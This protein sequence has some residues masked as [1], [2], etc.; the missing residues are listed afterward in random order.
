VVGA[1][2]ALLAMAAPARAQMDDD[3]DVAPREF[4]S[5]ERFG[6]EFRI[7]PYSPDMGGNDAF[8]TV[9]DDDIGPMLALEFDVI[10][11]RLKKV[12]SIGGG[13]IIGRA[14]FDGTTLSPAGVETSEETT[15]E[16]IPLGL[17]AVL[18]IDALSRQFSVPFNFA[19]KLGYQWAYWDTNSGGQDDASG[20]SDGLVWGAQVALDLDTLEKR[21]ARMLDEEYGI[22]HS[23]LFFELFSFEPSS[24]SL[25]IGGLQ[26]TAGLGFVM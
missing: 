5:A 10:A 14:G 18:R 2:L 20:W 7:G 11:W 22:N 13:G 17:L 12:L 24:S 25:E 8:D 26:W 6:L 15:L 19:G 1:L 9:F 21:Q 16:I 23:F 4:E 3:A